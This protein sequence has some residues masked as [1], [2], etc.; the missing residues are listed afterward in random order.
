MARPEIWA[1][2]EARGGSIPK[3]GCNR[4][5][6]KRSAQRSAVSGP[7]LLLF[8]F[9]ML[10]FSFSIAATGIYE[11]ASKLSVFQVPGS[12]KEKRLESQIEASAFTVYSVNAKKSSL[13]CGP[14]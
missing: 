14:A 13:N 9:L 4:R 12:R 1:D 6:T 3:G 5:T 10:I 7:H 8:T 11:M 2:R